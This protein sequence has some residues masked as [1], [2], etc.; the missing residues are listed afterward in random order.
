MR[1]YREVQK[2]S[3]GPHGEGFALDL[4]EMKLVLDEIYADYRQKLKGDDDPLSSPSKRAS[5]SKSPR[6]GTSFSRQSTQKR[7]DII[8]RLAKQ[9]TTRPAVIH[10]P[11]D[12]WTTTLASYAY[13]YDHAFENNSLRGGTSFPYDMACGRLQEIKAKATGPYK[14]TTRLFY[15][16]SKI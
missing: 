14:C 4:K 9:F 12:Q 15:D 2:L 6:K 13:L 7:Q 16:R 3:Q 1:P 10:M 8:R 11:A 5:P